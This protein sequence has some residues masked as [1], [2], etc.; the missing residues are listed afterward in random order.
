LNSDKSSEQ[1]GLFSV[2]GRTAVVTGSGRNIGKA[3]AL[4]LARAGANVVVNGRRANA[5]IDTVNE[6]EKSGGRAIPIAADISKADEVREMIDQTQRIFG[7][8]DIVVSNVGVRKHK[9]FLELSVED[10]K[11]ALDINLNAAF[12]LAQAA[13]PMMM[14]NHWGRFIVMSGLDAF[15]APD[16][17]RAHIVVSKLGL[18]GLIKAVAREF[19]PYGITANAIAPGMLNTD[20]DWSQFPDFNKE[21]FERSLPLRRMGTPNDV[22][23]TT[24]FLCSDAAAFITGQALHVNGGQQMF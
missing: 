11:S 3:I 13:L 20:R 17:E 12:H 1:A 16:S 18:Y 4:T 15:I 8:V 7:S 24:L 23:A 21:K 14:K 10:W 19:G 5:L 2:R 6:I 9:P 22:A